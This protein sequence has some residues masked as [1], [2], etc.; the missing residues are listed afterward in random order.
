METN[1]Q[2]ITQTRIT[3]PKRRNDLITRQRLLDIMDEL[4]E[5]K[6]IIIA[7][8]AGYGKT[9]LLI[10]FTGELAI[11][12][13][14][15]ALDSYDQ[16]LYRFVEYFVASIQAQ[17]PKFGTYALNVLHSSQSEAEIDTLVTALSNDI[18]E[19]IT[20]HFIFILDDY[21]LVQ[22]N[23]PINQF[24]SRFLQV[25]EE[26][27]H[28]IFASRTLITLPDLPLLVAR[29]LVGGISFEDLAFTPEEVRELF[30]TNN[31]IVISPNEAQA[32]VS[33][34]EGWITGLL[35]TA[36]FSI[37]RLQ[38]QEK[39]LKATGVDLAKYFEQIFS[40]QE[41]EIQE[42]LLYTSLLEDFNFA[43]VNNTIGKLF[44]WIS[45]RYKMLVDQVLTSNLFVQSVGEEIPSLRYHHLFLDFL[46]EKLRLEQNQTYHQLQDI[47]ASYYA[48]NQQ[49]E[50][51]YQIYKKE[52]LKEKLIK[53][54]ETAG[55]Y[56]MSSGRFGILQDWL[57][58]LPQEAL[59]KN[60]A[61]CAVLGGALSM[62]GDINNALAYLD[63]ALDQLDPADK[64]DLTA[65]TL[66]RKGNTLRMMGHFSEAIDVALK[67]LD[68]VKDNLSMRAVRAEANK[69]I[70]SSYYELG[71][72]PK[73]FQYLHPAYN[74]YTFLKMDNEIAIISLDMGTAY[75]S[76]GKFDEAK[77]YYQFDVEYWE[78]TGNYAWLANVLN[79]LAVLQHLAGD[80]ENAISNLERTL[81]Y[82][83]LTNYSRLEA[84]A[85]NS[86]ADLY[87]DLGAMDEAEK[88]Y[89]DSLQI[90][91][92]INAKY[93]AV[94]SYCSLAKVY[95]FTDKLTMAKDYISLASTV[96]KEIN[97]DF[98]LHLVTFYEGLLHFKS[99]EFKQAEEKF[100]ICFQFFNQN[101][102][103]FFVGTSALYVALSLAAT[104]DKE[105]LTA[106]YPELEKQLFV[107]DYQFTVLATAQHENRLLNHLNKFLPESGKKSNW[108]SI[109]ND[110]R[111]Q[112]PLNRRKLRLKSNLV[113]FAPAR[114]EIISLGDMKV[115][116]HDTWLK[117]SDWQTQSARDFFF[118]ILS[119]PKGLTKEEIG[120]LL[121]PDDSEQELKFH[122][123]NA[124][125]RVRHAIG[126]ESVLL[127][128]DRYQF[129]TN[130]DYQFDA[131]TFRKTV[132]ACERATSWQ[133][134]LK[135][136]RIASGIY[137]GV[138]LPDMHVEW[139]QLE[140]EKLHRRYFEMMVSM[141]RAAFEQEE[142]T[143][144]AE[145]AQKAIKIDP[146][147]EE[148]Y[149]VAMRA[150]AARGNRGEIARLYKQCEKTLLQE[151]DVPP[152]EKTKKTY[153]SLMRT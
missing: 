140:R 48:D 118:L 6:I 139:I 57:S 71:N 12:V 100:F 99:K 58:E 135:Y 112:L 3:I 27:F 88:L 7:A 133:D 51:A 40:T 93:S 101:Q 153:Q 95:L 121:W 54:L 76:S 123:K 94:Y 77:K 23:V 104:N 80:I 63:N 46:Q 110:F 86:I 70:G 65:R 131:D 4:L 24:L 148:V 145:I 97:S 11:P 132:R 84:G 39:S 122:F 35:L 43:L 120:L 22:N 8:P 129:N 32:L 31:Q 107:D 152:S 146:T 33:K 115:K 134:K 37:S 72:I 113:P 67:A 25:A 66:T 61:L 30:F 36:Q 147:Q 126:K 21:H 124:I 20:E 81:H 137:R 55:P 64:P 150:Q 45:N 42:F 96:A 116:Y 69:I 59:L 15:Y 142:F 98:E 18:Y 68:I 106:I 62:K 38:E 75:S 53:L 56:L 105:T 60:A 78:K 91:L 103:R 50:N 41:K 108:F 2:H 9:S 85:L 47:I 16:S 90:A 136:Y 149:R 138:Y 17:F 127:D 144:A 28:I 19:N 10:D 109:L 92:T 83:R 5:K 141:S 14:W 111:Q 1:N 29:G 114:L 102:S 13:C 87:G 130:L 73:S 125:Y 151:L 52:G 26:N 89:Q 143:L 44:P 79:N 34:T 49:W 119:Q 74:D 82:A 128:G 117:S